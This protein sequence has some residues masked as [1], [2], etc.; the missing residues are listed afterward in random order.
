MTLEEAIVYLIA[1]GG[2]G[3]TV[4]QIVTIINARQLYRRKDG[5]PVTLAQVYATIMRRNDIFV[6]E[7]GRIR[8]MM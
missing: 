5:Q 2:H 7:E 1:G 4:E 8:V 3:L 6:K